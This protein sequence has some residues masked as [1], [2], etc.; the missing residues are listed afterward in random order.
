[1]KPDPTEMDAGAWNPGITSE[2]PGGLM[3]L[4]TLYRPENA[5]VDVTQAKEAAAFCGLKTADMIS[6]R[7]ERLV[8]HELLIRVTADLSV[9]DGPNY[10]DLGISLRTMVATILERHIEPRMESVRA[11]FDAVR[12]EVSAR[13]D[14]ELTDQLYVPEKPPSPVSSAPS[15][16]AR[17]FGGVKKQDRRSATSAASQNSERAREI[18]AVE[19]WKS[20]LSA[21]D[22]PL[23]RAC[24]EALA[25]LVGS[26]LGH[27]GRLVG[28]LE[29]I[30]TLATNM[31]CNGYGSQQVGQAI[32]PFVKQAIEAEGYRVLPAQ[33]KPVVMNVKGASASGKSTIRPQQRKLAGRIGI[34]WEDFALISPDYWRKFLLDYDSLGGHK[35]YAAMLT[36]QELEMI[37]KKLDRY[38]AAKAARGAMSHLL[39]DR[40]RF[41]SFTLEPDRTSDSKLLTRFG[42]LIFMFFM[43]TP[44]SETVERAWKRG[45]TTGRFKAVDDLL[46]HN[47]EAYTGIPNLFFSWV[48]S[49]KKRVHFEFLDNDVPLGELPRTAAFGWNR[50]MTILDIQA[51]INIDRYR[52]VDVEALSPDE[53]FD[54]KDM[55]L[56][57]NISFIKRCAKLIPEI[58]LADQESGYIYARFDHGKITWC[59]RPYIEKLPLDSG[60]KDSLE[61]FGFS[62]GNGPEDAEAASLDLAREKNYTLG[63]WNGPQAG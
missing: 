48:L 58:H 30:G 47:V 33:E 51:M 45:L 28:D 25:K 40:F 59:D 8:V 54:P 41:D 3:P 14:K 34:P 57:D 4:V 55:A 61:A 35:K 60:I 29:T 36:G 1:M 20:R 19:N 6:L 26:I 31:V 2:I 53:V 37:D 15:I 21:C 56:R 44:P 13:I 63:R 11:A 16:F 24:L 27:R 32:E 12:T 23:E 9:P 43:I 22:D 38:M 52:K 46:Y 10:E 49:T 42:D 18:A 62:Q 5:T 39:I 7:V 50:S 17:L